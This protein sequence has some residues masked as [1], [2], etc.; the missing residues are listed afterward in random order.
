MFKFVGGTLGVEYARTLNNLY[1]T[2]LPAYGSFGIRI[3]TGRFGWGGIFDMFS[4]HTSDRFKLES[5]ERG[6]DSFSEQ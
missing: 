2:F 5:L 4:T 1:S 6:F 3:N